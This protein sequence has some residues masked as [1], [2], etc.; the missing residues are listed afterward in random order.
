MKKH[1]RSVHTLERPYKCTYEA[2][3]RGFVCSE[4]LKKHVLSHTK[5]NPFK[6]GYCELRFN[7][8]YSLRGHIRKHHPGQPD[9]VPADGEVRCE[10]V[11]KVENVC[12]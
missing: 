10:K 7:Q 6:C 8:N 1:V 11:I 2:C 3:G 12:K 5:E 9:E 4:L